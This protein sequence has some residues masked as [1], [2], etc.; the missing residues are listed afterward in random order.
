VPI[1]DAMTGE[2][3]EAHLFIAVV[4]TT[5]SPILRMSTIWGN[6]SG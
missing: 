3:H 1:I 6:L 4:L 5:S 2:V